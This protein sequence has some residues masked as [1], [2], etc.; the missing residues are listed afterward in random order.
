MANPGL[1]AA[2][3]EQLSRL[4]GDHANYVTLKEGTK[5]PTGTYRLHGKRRARARVLLTPPSGNY[6]VIP[7]AG[8][9]VLDIDVH[10]AELK[11]SIEFFEKFFG[12]DLS[13][14]L[15]VKTPSGG[16][17]YYLR[18]PE[19]FVIFNGSLRSY[20]KKIA[21]FLGEEIP[22]IDADIRSSDATGY[23]VGPGS[24]VSK[25]KDG[26]EYPTP[27]HY[28]LLGQSREILRT[29]DFNQLQVISIRAAE[30][31]TELRNIQ[32]ARNNK[33]PKPEIDRTVEIPLIE[34]R[35]DPSTIAKL[36]IGLQRR[37]KEIPELEFHRKRAF[38]SGAL[39][40][41]YSD[42]TIAV[43]CME[44]DVDRDSYTSK[45]LSMWEM[46]EDLKRLRERNQNNT[47]TVYCRVGIAK[48]R[49]KSTKTLDDFIAETKVKVQNRTIARKNTLRRPK[50][51]HVMKII[52]RLEAEKKNK[53]PQVTR[54]ALLLIDVLFQPLMNAGASKIVLAVDPVAETLRLTRSRVTAATRLLRTKRIISLIDKQKTGLAPTYTVATDYIHK[55]L[56]S[57]IKFQWK[58]NKEQHELNSIFI[59]NRFTTEFIDMVTGEIHSLGFEVSKPKREELVS[60]PAVPLD[61][62]AQKYLHK[63]LSL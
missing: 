52:A 12:V 60:Q 16:L 44:L 47:H 19:G 14:T 58:Q 42:Y 25:M 15:Y 39:R 33:T 22:T 26:S 27:G 49:S 29:G 32:K 43:A 4:L 51:I 56:T 10:K 17:H 20:S 18:I 11:Q 61:V 24:F 35:P 59:Y 3:R 48:S 36:R 1:S 2:T 5:E 50:V 23:V 38:V 63:E 45:R 13:K 37:M 30:I 7:V 34:S 28:H 55:P 31:L 62:F 8:F 53:L 9:F 21:E 46:I 40:C 57:A 54:D 6:G 41:C